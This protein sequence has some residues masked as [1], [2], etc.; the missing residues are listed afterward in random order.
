VGDEQRPGY[1][2]WSGAGAAP[3]LPR[4]E[5]GARA[6]DVE[7]DRV[8]AGLDSGGEAFQRVAGADRVRPLVADPEQLS[9]AI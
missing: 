8:R 9:S 4:G 3:I 7:L 1:G 2:S 5:V 6:Q